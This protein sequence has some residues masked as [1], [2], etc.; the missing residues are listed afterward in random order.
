MEHKKPFDSFAR[1]AHQKAQAAIDHATEVRTRAAEELR[2]KYADKSIPEAQLVDYGD[3]MRCS[4][5]EFPFD[6][7]IKPSLSVAFREHLFK[8]HAP[9]QTSEGLNQ[10]AARIVKE[11]TEKL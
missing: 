6:P 7:D 1:E 3:V 2:K 11:T 8:A 10:A 5:C 4:V 9:G